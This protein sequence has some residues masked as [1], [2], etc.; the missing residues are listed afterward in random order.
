MGDDDYENSPIPKRL[1]FTDA[2]LKHIKHKYAQKYLIF[3]HR[4]SLMNL[5]VLG[6][7]S[8]FF[9]F[10]GEDILRLSFLPLR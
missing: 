8:R 10:D 2:A 5:K 9:L 3:T 6:Q 7:R 4:P 1:H